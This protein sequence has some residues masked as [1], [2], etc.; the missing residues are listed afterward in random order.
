MDRMEADWEFE[1]GGD[2][3]IIEA[4][5][6]GFVDL[7]KDPHRAGELTEANELAGLADAL[8]RLNAVDSPVW[9]SKTD[10]FEPGPYDPDELDATGEEAEHAIACYVDLLGCDNQQWNSQIRADRWCR[11]LCD[12]LRA[13]PLKCCRVDLVVRRAHIQPDRHDL[14]ATAYFTACGRSAGVAKVRLGECLAAFASAMGTAP[15]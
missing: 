10:V 15:K 8:A 2:A 11:T 9:T 6:P 7:R 3:P 14:A 12:R 5:W 1:V 13:V 4:Q